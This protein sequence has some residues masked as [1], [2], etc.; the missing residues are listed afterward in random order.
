MSCVG[1][2]TC[3][4][5]EIGDCMIRAY[6]AQMKALQIWVALLHPSE[7]NSKLYNQLLK[8]VLTQL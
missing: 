3:M 7:K 2:C 5:P 8:D 6:K 4:L 1:N